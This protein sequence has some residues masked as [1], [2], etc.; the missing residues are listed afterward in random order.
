MP[1]FSRPGVEAAV[2]LSKITD[3]V[4]WNKI[5]GKCKNMLELKGGDKLLELEICCDKISRKWSTA[6]AD[7]SDIFCTLGELETI[8]EWKFSKGKPRPLWKQ[9]R[10]NSEQDVQE[11]SKRAFAIVGCRNDRRQLDVKKTRG[12]M[13]EITVL[14]GIGPASASAMLS[15]FRPDHFA[16]MDDEVIE[17]LHPGKRAYSLKVYMDINSRCQELAENLGEDWTP[18]RVGF[19]LWTAAKLSACGD[20]LIPNISL[21]DIDSEKD[22]E[23]GVKINLN[24]KACKTETI[25]TE[26]K[27]RRSTRKRRKR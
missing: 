7:D 21:N 10:S 6:N 14:K 19:A 24:D 18:R 12:A 25:E 4:V 26:S 22:E 13:N 3:V 9:I 20:D 2:R 8:I 1:T 15:L 17:C 23:I 5:E 16:F 27:L 11:A